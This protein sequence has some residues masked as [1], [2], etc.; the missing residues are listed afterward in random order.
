MDQFDDSHTTEPGMEVEPDPI[1]KRKSV[2]PTFDRLKK[3][4]RHATSHPLHFHRVV[5]KVA[6]GIT[7]QKI[8]RVG[9]SRAAKT[10]PVWIAL[11]PFLAKLLESL[12]SKVVVPLSGNEL[13]FNLDI[14]FS[15]SML[16]FASC[17]FTLGNMV[18]VFRCPNFVALYKD[19]AEFT[20]STG[21]SDLAIR[22]AFVEQLQIGKWLTD[23]LFKVDKCHV[24]RYN[25]MAE[26]LLRFSDSYRIEKLDTENFHEE[27]ASDLSGD[28]QIREHKIPNAFAFVHNRAGKV[29]VYSRIA[30]QLLYE[31]G[32]ALLGWVFV[33]AVW[34][35]MQNHLM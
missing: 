28:V 32:F 4:W 17:L 20:E 24:E 14:P 3:E 2:S 1:R 13:Q 30:C 25:L 22:D 16:F 10:A 35:M 12:P 9:V 19:Y 8:R 7:W 33:T 26:F 11:I 34:Y 29:R 18:Y 5:E 23:D 6:A 27:L 31:A 21:G 15:W